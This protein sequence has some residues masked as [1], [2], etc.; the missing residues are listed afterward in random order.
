MT[1]MLD[2]GA[3]LVTT[4]RWTMPTNYAFQKHHPRTAHSALPTSDLARVG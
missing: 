2:G 4:T 3:E 1:A